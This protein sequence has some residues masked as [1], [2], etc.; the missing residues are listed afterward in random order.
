MQEDL[1]RLDNYYSQQQQSLGQDFQGEYMQ[2]MLALKNKIQ[3]FLKSYSVEKGYEYVFATSSDD[4][5][6]YY[7]DSVRNITTDIVDKLNEQYKN[8]KTK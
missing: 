8:S 2:K 4:N 1:A 7:K 6:I 5:V 3:A